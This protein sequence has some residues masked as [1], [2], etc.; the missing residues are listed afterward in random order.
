MLGSFLFP[1][2]LIL[3]PLA[4]GS[5]TTI[6]VMLFLAEFFSG[7]GL[8][9]QDIS[10]GSISQALVPDRMRA[11]VAGGYMFVNNGV[12]PIGSL[13]GGVLG[14][15]LGVQPTLLIATVGSVLGVLFLLRSPA[16]SLRDLPETAE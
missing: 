14:G 2:P 13:M 12:R 7:F 1:A 16:P 6:L 3:V 15:M 9:M 10:F 4:G 8:M 5:M 11:R